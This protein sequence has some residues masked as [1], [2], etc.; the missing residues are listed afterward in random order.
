VR[1]FPWQK[2]VSNAG[3]SDIDINKLISDWL[4]GN[5]ADFDSSVNVSGNAV[6]NYTA[7]FACLRVLAETLAS[8]PI[9]EFKKDLTSGDKEKTNET[10]ILDILKHMPNDE[11]DS[12]NFHVMG[13]NQI[14]LGGN[15]VAT[16]VMT[17]GKQLHSLIPYQW[18]NVRIL[19][20][21]KS[22]KIQ[23]EIKLN[24]KTKKLPKNKVFHVMGPTLDGITGL[25]PVSHIANATKLGLI[26]EKFGINYFEKGAFT[27][28][29]FE[30]PG[31]LEETAYNRLQQDLEENKQRLENVGKPMLLE[32]G[33]KFNPVQ[34]KLLDAELLRSKRFQV[35]D[36]A[37]IYRV[38][39]HFIM[40]LEKATFSNIEH[41]SLE[42]VIFT[43]LPIVKRWESAINTQLLMREQRDKGFFFEYNLSGLLRADTKAMS[44][45]FKA[46]RQ[47]GW[48]SVNDIRRLLNMNGIGS[49]GD[50][51]LQPLNMVEA[52]TEPKENQSNSIMA[53][54]QKILAEKY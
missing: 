49:K 48:L 31:T 12:Y 5:R 35:V 1:I 14:N 54:V 27:T 15:L 42:F 11:M 45:A 47:W 2:K 24:G 34:M 36:I 21:K 22:Q 18:Q 51:Y 28:G 9:N 52:G 38:P 39:P 16:K 6:L 8:L 25:T 7:V 23:Y 37:R 41:Q 19:R 50:I 40:E 17:N 53:E 33:L 20:D 44:E 13:S 10:G 26:Y 4:A 29:V 32:D 30:H 46:G 43:M 3:H